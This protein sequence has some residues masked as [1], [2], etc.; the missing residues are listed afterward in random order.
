MTLSAFGWWKLL[1]KTSEPVMNYSQD[2]RVGRRDKDKIHKPEEVSA[3][4]WV[5]ENAIDIFTS[6]P[7]RVLAAHSDEAT[8]CTKKAC[9]ALTIDD[10]PNVYSTSAILDVLA[11]HDAVATFFLIG[12]KAADNPVLVRRI[13]LEGNEIGNHS[14]AHP[15][16]TKLD[17]KQIEDQV[18]HT[19][20]V[21]SGAGI[22]APKL[23]R[24]PYGAINQN[25]LDHINLPIVLWNVDPRDWAENNPAKITEMVTAQ[26][27]QGCILLIHDHVAT[28]ASMEGIISNLQQRF[29]LVTA[30]QL[31]NIQSNARGVYYSQYVRR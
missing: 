21:I 31:L 8:D 30:S 6:L 20:S 10:G 17:G 29:V 2:H 12:K 9:I 25:V 13:Y 1:V 4:P 11:R 19:Q 7:G 15:F 24:S 5:T 26:A 18:S 14:W 23:V 16:F 3:L 27:K 22:P 28:A